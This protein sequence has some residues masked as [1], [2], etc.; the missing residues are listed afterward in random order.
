MTE[1][2][3]EPVQDPVADLLAKAAPD[4]AAA[5]DP[6]PTPDPAEP[7]AAPEPAKDV[8]E[9]TKDGTID[10][11]TMADFLS[12]EEDDLDDV[13]P[14]K[15]TAPASSSEG[16]EPEEKDEEPTPPKDAPPEVAQ[17][18]P[19]EP[20]PGEVEPPTPPVEPAPEQPLPTAPQAA[21]AEP[22]PTPITMDEMRENYQKTRKDMEVLV[23]NE[24]YGFSEEQVQRLDDGDSSL[25]P[26]LMAKVYMDAVTGATA[27]MLTH[28]PALVGQVL[29]GRDQ[30]SVLEEK[31]YQFWPTIKKEEHAQDVS[32]FGAAYRQ[33]YPD[34]PVEDFIRDVGAQVIV[35]LKIPTAEAK[36]EV[37]VGES[38]PS[39]V[40]PLTPAFQPAAAGGGGAAP[41]TPTNPYEALS[42]EMG[43]ED[44]DVG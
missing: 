19:A 15:D 32:R 40:V 10:S 14:V 5:A 37:E 41:T 33:L 27:H 17:T 6:T 36:V 3:T 23:A 1:K 28:L 43:L 29:Q 12:D 4:P 20:K 26:E 44:V 31:F 34:A 25:I 7:A 18:T 22:T 9:V 2:S 13:D 16:P 38:S 11:A 42:D 35:A 39:L 24:V 8:P 30:T 21:P